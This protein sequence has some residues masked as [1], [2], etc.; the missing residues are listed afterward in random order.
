[1]AVGCS[2]GE[3]FSGDAYWAYSNAKDYVDAEI[4]NVG[5]PTFAKPPEA[6]VVNT[7]A[8]D[9]EVKSWVEYSDRSATTVRKNF[10][11]TVRKKGDLTYDLIWLDFD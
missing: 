1:M 2:S 10:T 6:T 8:H 11:A 9:W 4:D 5:S 3:S 7:E